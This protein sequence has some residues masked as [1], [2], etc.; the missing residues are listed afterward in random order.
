VLAAGRHA[1]WAGR[2]RRKPGGAPG[3]APPRAAA[4]RAAW[5]QPCPSARVHRRRLAARV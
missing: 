3:R 1:R 2:L 4:G 5:P